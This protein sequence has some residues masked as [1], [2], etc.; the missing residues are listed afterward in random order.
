VIRDNLQ[1]LGL[2]NRAEVFTSKPAPVL[3][4]LAADIVFLDP[5]YEMEREYETA[6]NALAAGDSK[7]MIVQHA[8]R[9]P[10]DPAYGRLQRFRIL[11][12][13]DNSLS[14]YE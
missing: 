12:Q 10:L 8:S 2:E 11:K 14:F 5:P 9:T 7:L 1:A 13:G 3:D 6:M 4:R